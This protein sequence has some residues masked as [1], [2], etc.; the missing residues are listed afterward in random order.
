MA[1]CARPPIRKAVFRLTRH[2]LKDQI[3]H[4]GFTDAVSSAVVFTSK[5]RR[6]L[7][8]LAIAVVVVA[9]IVAA[10]LWYASSQ[11][12]VRQQ[13]LEA[14]LIVAQA[15]VGASN[16]G[17]MSYPTQDA[18]NQASLKALSEVISKHGGSNEGLV[19][20]Y[21]R[22]TVE[23]NMGNTSAAQSD[24]KTVANSSSQ[25]AS[26]AKVALAQIDAGENRLA[27]AQT[28]L[29]GLGKK[30]SDLVSK[31]QAEI[32]LAQMLQTTDPKKS[33][34]ILQSLKND[35]DPAVARTVTQLAGEQAR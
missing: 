4:D 8:R 24:L 6:S 25:F 16:Q 7:I 2:E 30:G 23:A 21:Y 31:A 28:I 3:Q 12:A 1:S 27:N 19:A 29:Q 17:G 35:K 5:H 15:P 33:K 14:A 10:A 34:D 22:G 13:D 20:Q 9:V 11:R 32:M 18:K 26:L